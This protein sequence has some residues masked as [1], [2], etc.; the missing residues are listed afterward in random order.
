MPQMRN[1]V[2]QDLKYFQMSSSPVLQSNPKLKLGLTYPATA[3]GH[4]R[5]LPAV[6]SLSYTLLALAWNHYLSDLS[7]KAHR[8][9]LGTNPSPNHNPHCHCQPAGLGTV[10]AAV[11]T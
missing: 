10:L 5:P 8:A 9:R 2:T 6:V 4:T 11:I 1:K 3:N 7:I